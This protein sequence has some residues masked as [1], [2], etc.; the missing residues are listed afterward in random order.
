MPPSGF[1]EKAI[2]G[3]LQFLEGCYEDLQRKLAANPEMDIRVAIDQEL[4]EV[5]AA[6]ESFTL[7]KL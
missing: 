5:R 4:A 1:N 2:R 3:L 7:Q 6:L